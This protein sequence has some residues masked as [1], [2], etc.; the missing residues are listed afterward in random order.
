MDGNRT[1]NYIKINNSA[2]Q[3]RTYMLP[4]FVLITVN[5]ISLFLEIVV[6]T[7]GIP[8]LRSPLLQRDVH[9][10]RRPKNRSVGVRFEGESTKR[11]RQC[12]PAGLLDLRLHLLL[13][14]LN[15]HLQQYIRYIVKWRLFLSTGT[16]DT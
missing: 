9:F 10:F 7:S 2:P 13:R 14:L 6:V 11:R 3:P 8:E 16:T 4:L 12:R 15:S 5:A 1:K